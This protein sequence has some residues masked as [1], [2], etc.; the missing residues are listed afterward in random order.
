MICF[1]WT[2]WALTRWRRVGTPPQRAF[3]ARRL[4]GLELVDEIGAVPEP[5][6]DGLG[7]VDFSIA[8]HYRSDHPEADAIERV[9]EYFRTNGMP[10][11]TLQDGQAIVVRD[12]SM[13][14]VEM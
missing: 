11:R 6:W 2:G 14:T 3:A 8:P 7:F 9:V 1:L 12:G 4:R 10:Y 13:R 5:V